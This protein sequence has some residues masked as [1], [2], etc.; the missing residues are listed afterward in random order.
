MRV[1]S[2]FET[3]TT[4]IMRD[5]PQIIDQYLRGIRQLNSDQK[6]DLD[7]KVAVMQSKSNHPLKLGY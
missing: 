3:I 5:P 4:K 7:C 1:G 2:E 6:S